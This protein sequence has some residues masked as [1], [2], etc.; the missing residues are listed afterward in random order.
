[1]FLGKRPL[2]NAVGV[3]RHTTLI[4]SVLSEFV[5]FF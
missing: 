2:T 1:M 3:N 5:I 4:F